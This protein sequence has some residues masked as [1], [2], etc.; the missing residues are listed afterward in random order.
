MAEG[1]DHDCGHHHN[2][3]GE[4]RLA[5]DPAAHELLN[6]ELQSRSIPAHVEEIVDHEVQ[7]EPVS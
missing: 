5:A 2:D 1:V 4:H 7:T 3:D 6:G